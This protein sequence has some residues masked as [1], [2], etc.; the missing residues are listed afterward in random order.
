MRRSDAIPSKKGLIQ[1]IFLQV[2]LTWFSL[3]NILKPVKAQATAKF[4]FATPWGTTGR[5]SN[6]GWMHFAAAVTV[7]CQ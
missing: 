1:R 4:Y 5:F 2:I 6:I 3:N 7:I